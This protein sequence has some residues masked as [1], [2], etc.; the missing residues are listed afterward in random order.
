MTLTLQRALWLWVGALVLALLVILP[1]T[2]WIR[3]IAGLTTLCAVLL[4]CV[5]VNRHAAQQRGSL[6]LVDLKNL[7]A[8]SF[9]KP[10]VLTCGDGLD[11]LFG[12]VSEDQV[13]LRVTE[14]GC[15]V[16]VPSLNQLV[17][18]SDGLL[19]LR[20]GWGGQLSVMLIVN[21]GA[22]SDGGV[23]G[24]QVRTFSH[25]VTV[26]RKRGI[27]LPLLLVSYLQ[28]LHGEEPWF[29][30]DCGQTDARV[31][32]EGACVSLSEWQRQTADSSLQAARMHASIQLN[33]VVAWLNDAV[34]RHL[35]IRNAPG[36]ATVCAV[37]LVPALPQAV[38]MNL[39]QQWLHSKVALA[40]NR[41]IVADAVLPFPDPLLNRLPLR[42]LRSPL[43]R[44][45]VAAMWLFAVAGVVALASSAWQNTLL[46]RQITDDLHRYAAIAQPAHRDQREFLRREEA[47]TVLRQDA[48][49]LDAYYRHGEPLAF[50]LGLYRGERLRAPLLAVLAKH[51][52]PP[53]ALSTGIAG[54]VRLDSLSLFATG[55]AQLKP[56]STK[57]LIN[58]LVD[59]KAQPGWLIVIA[60]HT[61][62]TGDAG[63]NLRLSHAR[64]S[65]VHDWM[66]HMGGIPDSCFAV[67]GFGASQ[68]I[69]SN[70]TEAG[71]ATN[72]RVDIR[73]VPEDGA[74]ALP[75]A[76]PDRQPPVAS[77]DV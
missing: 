55:S 65:A 37:K 43:Q 34:L 7:P 4:A 16:R 10:V 27:E 23:L 25:Q 59:I 2:A 3:S 74:C 71:R 12:A 5:L 56:D 20:P 77:R 29:S 49:R 48:R 51:V 64:A 26:A 52:E 11:G 1:L 46:V 45:S 14:Q 47:V 72:R 22:H 39:W 28:T 42:P 66:Q 60:G 76:G 69:A 38:K 68:P 62:A 54:P 57:V 30:W 58:A 53:A 32:D 73:L 24:G 17:P 13:V 44:A 33:S 19:A 35:A 15:Y 18:V 9:R 41:P 40:D 61:D 67:Q 36:L 70:D 75:T 8:A 50:G 31:S 63:N 21:P 6:G